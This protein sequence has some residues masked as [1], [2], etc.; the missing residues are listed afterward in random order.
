[1]AGGA[2]VVEGL[3]KI[4]SSGV[5]ALKGVSFSVEGGEIFGLLGPNGA[6]KTTLVRILSTLL[7]PTRGRALVAGHDVVERPNDVRRSIGYVPQETSVDDDLTG[8]EN[9]MLQARLY[10]VPRAEAETRARELLDLLELTDAARRK[11]ETYSGGMRRRLELAGALLHEPSVLFLDEP[12]LGLDVHTR[13]KI[14]EYVERLRRE[15]GVTILM[16]THYMEEADALCDR[17]AIIDEG[18]IKAVGSPSELKSSI[19]GDVIELEAPEVGDGEIG[20]L[21]RELGRDVIDVAL[22]NG[23]LRVKARSGEKLLPR[24][25]E[26]LLTNGVRIESVTL[27]RPALDEVFLE[28]T[29]SRL[30]DERWSRED[31]RRFRATLRARRA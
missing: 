3:E 18:E 19:G 27:K 12:T 6:G 16:T 1:M 14:W 5:R 8:W 21:R 11:V 24:L 13:A 9:L 2:V 23:V 25:I 20:I 29:G 4:Y 10:H 15:R 17:V 28:L 31:F 30:R 22:V 26:L 7:K